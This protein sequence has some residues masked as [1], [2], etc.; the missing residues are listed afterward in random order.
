MEVTVFSINPNP[1]AFRWWF[2]RWYHGYRIIGKVSV[3]D[4]V[5]R[6]E[7]AAAVRESALEYRGS[8]KCVIMPR[9]GV[10]VN[11]EHGSFDFV[12]CYECTKMI[13]YDGDDVVATLDSG[14]S[15]D[16]LDGILRAA[17]IRQAK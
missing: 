4:P 8:S 16:V 10:R 5:L 3:K 2:S 17:R 14:G 1:R 6:R 12:I 11:S 9:H 13:I 7:A 15:S